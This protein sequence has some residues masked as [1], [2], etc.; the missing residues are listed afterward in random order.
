M[1]NFSVGKYIPL[2]TPL[3]RADPRPKAILTVFAC[4]M[5]FVYS[6]Y[7]GLLAIAVILFAIIFAFG[8]PLGKILNS[9]RSVIVIL[10][11]TVA[12]HFFLPPGGEVLAQW[13]FIRITDVGL[14]MGLMLAGR[15]FLLVIILSLLTITTPPLRLADGIESLLKPLEII[16]LPVSKITT[17]MSITLR[18]VPSIFT[19]SQKVIRAQAAR[20]ADFQ[21]KNPFK[22]VKQVFP[23][24]IP[25]FVKAFRS[26]EELAVAM[27]SRGYGTG[28]SRSHL[29]PLRWRAPEVLISLGLIGLMLAPLFVFPVI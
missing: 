13:G 25:L 12:F 10:I 6:D 1:K 16:R 24:M 4:I 27:D 11:V 29:Y 17:V 2:D 8:L 21:S 22:R 18:F 23:L 14:N 3:H 20:G 7:Q 19:H 15:I 9:V 5:I 28:E 26:A